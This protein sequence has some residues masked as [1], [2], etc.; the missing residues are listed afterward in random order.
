MPLYNIYDTL[1]LLICGMIAVT[2]RQ[3]AAVMSTTS[4]VILDD[5]ENAVVQKMS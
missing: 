3:V 5:A 4:N 2:A 1:Q